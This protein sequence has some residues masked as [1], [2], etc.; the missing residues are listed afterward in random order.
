MPPL[1]S[2]FHWQF[3]F[4]FVCCPCHP[5]LVANTCVS[6][7]HLQQLLCNLQWQFWWCWRST[8]WK[9]YLQRKNMHKLSSFIFFSRFF[10]TMCWNLSNIFSSFILM[11]FGN[12]NSKQ[13]DYCLLW[14]LLLDLPISNTMCCLSCPNLGLVL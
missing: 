8:H 4:T 6:Q 10:L 1:A 7:K 13:N 11:C 9:M 12:W 5:H 3:F 14:L 2:K